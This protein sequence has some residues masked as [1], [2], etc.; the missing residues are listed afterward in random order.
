M[1]YATVART[2]LDGIKKKSNGTVPAD[3]RR[4]IERLTQENEH[5][6]SAL[7]VAKRCCESESRMATLWMNEALAATGRQIVYEE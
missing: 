3:L 7:A 2:P 4:E 1:S 6:K 5:L